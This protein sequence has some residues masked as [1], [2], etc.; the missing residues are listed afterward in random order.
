MALCDLKIGKA[1]KA[2]KFAVGVWGFL[3]LFLGSFIF[4]LCQAP[5][6][7]LHTSFTHTQRVKQ[8]LTCKPT[9]YT[10]KCTTHTTIP[11]SHG[12]LFL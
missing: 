3:I 5:F 2:S 9:T 8:A 1:P 6:R 4:S 11:I 12:I 10:Y 7:H